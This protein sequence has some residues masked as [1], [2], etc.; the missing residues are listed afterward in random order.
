MPRPATRDRRE[1]RLD[2]LHQSLF[3]T[4]PVYLIKC[5]A[6]TPGIKAQA[7]E[8]KSMG[9]RDESAEEHDQ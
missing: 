1:V 5:D 8:P 2:Y 4:G 9:V 7:R 3:N 6:E